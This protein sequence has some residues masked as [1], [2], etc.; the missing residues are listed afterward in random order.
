MTVLKKRIYGLIGLPLK[1]SFSASMH[2]AAF[3]TLKINAEYKL[4]EIRPQEVDDFMVRLD[5]NNISGLNVTV[6]Y[7]EKVLKFVKLDPGSSFL[8]Q[9]QA[10]NTIVKKDGLW[11]GFNTDIP[12][13]SRHLKEQFDPAGKRAAILGAGGAAKAVAYVLASLKAKTIS[14]FDIDHQKSRN[15][16]AM[17]KEIFPGFPIYPVDNIKG[18]EIKDKDLLINATPVGLK[19]ED[20]C[21]LENGQLHSNLFVYDLVY[22]PAQTKLLVLAKQ[23]GARTSNGLGMLLYQGMLSFRIW[24]GQDAPRQ[25]MEE[26]LN[27]ELSAKKVLL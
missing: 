21:L 18:L 14:V 22:N 17:I 23:A 12:G 8:R 26:A 20:S 27:L 11:T 7:K 4:F 2:N 5:E 1:H 15:I 16:S 9:V 10:V 3:K 24:T 19:E 13:F 25:A 6:P